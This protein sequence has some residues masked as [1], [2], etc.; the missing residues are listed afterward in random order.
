M[1]STKTNT[2]IRRSA[3]AAA[4]AMALGAAS[5]A[6]AGT[7]TVQFESNANTTKRKLGSFT[8][9][10]AYDDATGLLTVTLNNTS[11]ADRG[12]HLTGVVFN[13]AGTTTTARYVDGDD[14]ASRGD[15]DAFDNA[16]SRKGLIKAKPLGTYDG[17]AAINGKFGSASRRAAAGGV[18][19]GSSRTFV[20]DVD[21]AAA[22]TT[23]ADFFS[24]TNGIA[25][26]FRGK[27]A[28]RVGGIVTPGTSSSPVIPGAGD[29]TTPPP[30]I[31]LPDDHTPPA[32]GGT[33]IPPVD[34][35]GGTGGA[36]NGANPG[37]GAGGIDGGPA[38]VPLPAA[39]WPGIVG[40]ALAVS[41]KIKRK[42]RQSL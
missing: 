41:T 27:K 7:T 22:G 5:P 3:T 2:T 13:I 42:L 19:A 38:A 37:N 33:I 8:G 32:G 39:A 17:G 25:A 9:S 11:A 23:A 36:V 15:E 34:V 29:V 26:A 1:K 16:R 12:G 20:F 24:G 18:S 31:D 35:G 4:V 6:L 21:N 28:D 40:L 30:V 14:A 10:A